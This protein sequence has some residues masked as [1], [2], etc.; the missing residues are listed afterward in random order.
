MSRETHMARAHRSHNN[1]K[2]GSR[3]MAFHGNGL[4]PVFSENNKNKNRMPSW[5]KRF[6]KWENKDKVK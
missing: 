6:G 2:I 1:F 3:D 4:I 5:E